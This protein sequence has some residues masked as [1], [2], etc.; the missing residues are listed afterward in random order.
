MSG[1]QGGL[2]AAR[3][4]GRL[5]DA[6]LQAKATAEVILKD[7][8]LPAPKSSVNAP[9]GAD[10][11]YLAVRADLADVKAIKQRLG[12]TVNDVVLAAVTSGLREL[13]LR[14]GDELP[15]EGL[16]AMVPVN[17]R[18]AAERFG[19]G[20][21]VSSLFVH[22][23]VAE[24]DSARRY[25]L[26]QADARELKDKG[27]ADGGA[28]LVALAGLAPPVLH[29]LF[30]RSLF[31][32][33]LFNVTVTNVPGPQVPFYAF[34]ARME[35][36]LPLVPI[37]ADHALGVAVV[38]YD[39]KLFF[40]LNADQRSTPDLGVLAEGIEAALAQL[41]ELAGGEPALRAAR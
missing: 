1:V 28:G 17:V 25:R 15:G 26:V 13:L 8:V 31:A 4:P 38:S 37:A 14:R 24:P 19:I 21:R 39:G 23:P 16:R 40:G 35:E 2:H 22:L 3:H 29:S 7:E 33:R 32:T 34:G 6:F 11:R 10:R 30:A 9:I 18:T 20:N 41:L 36:V 5:R 27:Y 12:G